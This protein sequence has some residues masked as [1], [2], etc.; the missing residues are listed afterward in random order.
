MSA[1]VLFR[2]SIAAPLLFACLAPCGYAASADPAP[3]YP[4]RPVRLIVPF[5]PGAGTDTTG[6]AIAAKLSERWGHQVVVDNRTGAAGSIGVELTRQASPDGYTLCLIS[7]SVQGTGAAEMDELDAPS[8]QVTTGDVAPEQVQ[9]PADDQ[10]TSGSPAGEDGAQQV[11]VEQ[12]PA[13]AQQAPD[14]PSTDTPK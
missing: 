14:Q 5:V 8:E 6:R 11:P 1:V 13:P 12:V 2:R 3:D 4:N 9:P 7:A 10:P